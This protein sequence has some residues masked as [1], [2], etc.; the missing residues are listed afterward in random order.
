MI[1]HYRHP[2]AT[3]CRHFAVATLAA[4]VAV[5]TPV[6]SSAQ[7]TT[8]AGIAP[9][10]M[11]TDNACLERDNKQSEWIALVTPDVSLTGKGRRANVSLSGSVEINSLTDSKLKDLG[12]VSSRGGGLTNRQQFAPRLNASADAIIVPEWFYID[13][14]A[15]ADQNQTTPFVGG[16]GDSL[17][18]RGNTNTTYRYD[19][20][21][22]VARQFKDVAEMLLRYTYSEQSNSADIIG[23][24]RQQTVLFTLGNGSSHNEITWG[25]QGDYDKIDYD[26]TRDRVNPGD[27]SELKSA[28]FNLAYQFTRKWQ[29]NGYYGQE[30]NDFVSASNDID[31]TFWDVGLR[32]TPNARTVIEA[33]R[34]NRFF[35]DTQR[36]LI[37]YRHKRSNLSA[38]YSED[39]S[40]DRN[41][42]NLGSNLPVGVPPGGGNVSTLTNSPILD[43]RLTL[44]YGFQ[45][46]RFS[47]GLQGSS[48]DQTREADGSDSTFRSASL[49]LGYRL[50]RHLSTSANV[51]W[52]EQD[53]KSGRTQ[54]AQKSETWRAGVGVSK[55]LSTGV[56][57]SLDYRYT[58]RSSDQVLDEY[59]EN[60]VTLTLR[61]KLL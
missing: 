6:A 39:L 49:S 30:W 46:R 58:D 11:F 19:V 4:A 51:G 47:L 36:Y 5:F 54:F 2:N 31:G 37:T 45:G 56:D 3:P 27:N 20:S 28:R 15:S 9:A 16:G 40:Y 41:I 50:G 32:W 61:I 13:A 7:W 42:R 29:I 48:S 44:S 10:V 34:G 23:Q 14:T 43:K 57:L 25:L 17:D 52:D 55:Q 59:R 26:V 8:S 35:G 21:P 1:R 38:Q 12:C 53:P 24:N 18:R 60:S 22:Y 33:G